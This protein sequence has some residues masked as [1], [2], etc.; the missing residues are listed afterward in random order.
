MHIMK[1]I[2]FLIA[3]M[4]GVT[5]AFADCTF[6]DV[7]VRQHW[8]W[9]SKVEV[10]MTVAGTGGQTHLVKLTAYSGGTLLGEIPMEK[11]VEGNSRLTF[12]FDSTKIDFLKNLGAIHDFRVVPS[13]R[14]ANVL[15]MDIDLTKAAG[16]PGQITYITEE[17][18]TSGAY[19]AFERKY[20]DAGVDEIAWTGV[21]ADGKYATSHLVMRRIPAGTFKM[22]SPA[23]ETNRGTDE[24]LQTDVTLTRSYYVGVFEVT[25]NQWNR[26]NNGSTSG[27]SVAKGGDAQQALRGAGRN[28]PTDRTVDPN[29][30]IGKLRTKTG[31]PFDLP[32]EAQW[33]KAARAGTVG[34]YYDGTEQ[35]DTSKL[36]ALA[37]TGGQ[38]D[39]DKVPHSVGL[40]KPNNYGLYDVLGNMAEKVL[41][42]Y[43]N[44]APGET[45]DPVGPE[46][47]SKRIY[48]GAGYNFGVGRQTRLGSRDGLGETSTTVNSGFRLA[49]PAQW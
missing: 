47:G 12:T 7:I 15:Y 44:P 1:R 34:V 25:E 46:S 42:W 39:A 4:T 26:I 18:I 23:G 3:L 33:E 2:M 37:W 40:L 32:T 16:E 22:G 20:W 30:W 17:D 38:A 13:A 5:A 14:Q 11:P 19:G 28:W 49:M 10:E 29:S 43:V 27:G 6:T 45:V 9:N 31:I 8:P 36:N 21:T 24:R 41:D 48:K 35:P